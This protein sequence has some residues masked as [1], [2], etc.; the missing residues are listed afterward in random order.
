MGI[1]K[2]IAKGLGYF[3]LF[4][5]LVI[6]IAL[7]AVAGFFVIVYQFIKMIY[8][9][10]TGRNLFGD[11]PEDVEVKRLKAINNTEETSLNNEA[12]TSPINPTPTVLEEPPTENEDQEIDDL[13]KEEFVGVDYLGG[14]SILFNDN[15]MSVNLNGV[16]YPLMIQDRKQ[17]SLRYQK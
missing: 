16:N 3:F 7:Y 8:L 6:A 9:F 4:P 15:E 11:L 14:I 5:I 17:H 1:L 2:S 13:E 12:N 10:F